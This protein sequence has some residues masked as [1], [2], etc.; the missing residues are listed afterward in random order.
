MC[1]NKTCFEYFSLPEGTYLQNKNGY[2]F[3]ELCKSG[4][5]DEN[6][7]QCLGE[8]QY[9]NNMNIDSNG[10]VQCNYGEDCI[11]NSGK[12]T[13]IK[14]CECGYNKE[15]KSYCPLSNEYN[16]RDWEELYELK[17]KYYKNDC[18]TLKR[19]ECIDIDI[20]DKIKEKYLKTENAH[21]IYNAEDAV[22]NTLSVCYLKMKTILLII[23]VL[24]I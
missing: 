23:F 14:K 4:L 5:I 6:T 17:K 16:K 1:M 8:L 20:I 15:G 21:L 18:H 3:K 10:F 9:N 12:K 24:I 7:N 2:L 22:I 19:D 11:Y 13:I